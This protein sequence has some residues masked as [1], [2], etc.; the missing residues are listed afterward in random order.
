MLCF[1]WRESNP[2]PCCT[3]SVLE[4]RGRT[5]GQEAFPAPNP[6]AGS[7]CIGSPRFAL[8]LVCRSHSALTGGN[9]G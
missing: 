7:S 8:T 2:L 1:W 3:S 4:W 5:G 9:G 6:H